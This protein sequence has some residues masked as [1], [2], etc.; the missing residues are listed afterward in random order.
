LVLGAN[1]TSHL[2]TAKRE[3]TQ[4]KL[5][6]A[7]TTEV[8]ERL[9]QSLHNA[10]WLTLGMER[11]DYRVQRPWSA[12]V[13]QEQQVG[14]VLATGTRIIEVFDRPDIARQ[15]LILGEPGSGKTTMMLELA[16]DLRERARVNKA[17]PIPV[18][19]S[20][21]GWKDPKQSIFDWLLAELKIK[22]GLRQDLAKQ[23]LT[24]HQL[25]PLL[26]GLDEVAPQHQKAC[27]LA[28]NAWLT[29][30]LAQRPCGVL[31]CCRREE[32]EQVV[33]EPLNLYG[34]IYLQALT[35][36]QI[37]EYFTQ[38]KLQDVWH[39]VH[40][41]AALQELLT[42]PLFLS[43]FGLVTTQRK[44]VI[45]AWQ[46]RTNS[47]K[48]IEYL[49]DTYWE[50]TIER[51]LIL[52]PN[53]RQRGIR[54]KT[55]GKK[56]LPS[57]QAV[58]RSLIF[59]AKTLD[60]DSSTELLIE[61]LQPAALLTRRQ[62]WAY[63]LIV[64]LIFGLIGGLIV[65]LIGGLI[66]G[67]KADIE[68]RIEPNQGI[69]N[70]LK[71]MLI[72]SAIALATALPFKFFLEHLLGSVVDPKI[73]PSIVGGSLFCLIWS[74]FQEGGGLALIQHLAL[75]IVLAWNRYAPFRYDLLLNYCTERLLL[76]R[77]GGRYRFMHK[78]FQD[79][80]AKMDL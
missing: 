20:L 29:G 58:L 18:L 76:Q 4:A 22:Y 67:L 54:S 7:V 68:T 73:L 60:R 45:D 9:A 48:K 32:F 52:D 40:Q 28:L 70:S 35:A 6:Q 59:A 77:I 56:S 63:R 27:A 16:Q 2:P 15:L 53:E 80:F 38:F 42:K 33:R 65:G 5:L 30:E 69:K 31:I 34:A 44:F 14:E 24:R 25:L 57:R 19:L 55:Y 17:E 21:S 46:D 3:P 23:W 51:E 50:A 74:G 8:K 49:L 10:V 62:K 1:D 37:A 78:L 39:T 11:Q 61:K 71:N 47:E 43:M 36:E 79:H 66:F 64:G 72:V 12:T 13:V 26:D 41:D 75:R